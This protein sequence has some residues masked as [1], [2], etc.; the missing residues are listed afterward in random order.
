M[1][2]IL[3]TTA[4]NKCAF[5]SLL[6]DNL[7]EEELLALDAYK[8]EKR[9]YKK[10][11]IVEQGQPIKEFLYLKEG[12]IKLVKKDGMEKEHIISIAKPLN[13][14]G[15]LSVFSDDKYQYSISALEDSVMCFIDL[16]VIKDTVRKN[17]EFALEVLEKISKISDD[18]IRFRMMIDRRQL[19]GRIA[20]ILVMFAKQVYFKSKFNLPLS[21]KEVAE[22]I[23]MSTENVI[24][25]LSEFRKDNIIRIDGSSIEILNFGQLER[26]CRFG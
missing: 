17:G 13:F 9:Y 15:F 3:N 8:V 21:R 20:Y 1:P 6:F 10:E 18:I 2:D 7:T 19:R 23:D 5:R 16:P 24:R 25:I 14:I 11:N 26:I 22:L 12:L 4:C